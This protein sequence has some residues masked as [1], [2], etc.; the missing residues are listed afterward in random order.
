[1]PVLYIYTLSPSLISP[2]HYCMPIGLTNEDLSWA[3]AILQIPTNTAFSSL[4]LGQ[5][6]QII[7]YECKYVYTIAAAVGYI[8]FHTT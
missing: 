3:T 6:V 1:M 2:A 8:S 4:N 5:A 7:G